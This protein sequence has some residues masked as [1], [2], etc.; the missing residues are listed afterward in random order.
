MSVKLDSLHITNMPLSTGEGWYCSGPQVNVPQWGRVA[1]LGAGNKMKSTAAAHTLQAVLWA[2][3]NLEVKTAEKTNTL[4]D[5][6]GW[7][8]YAGA[9]LVIRPWWQRVINVLRNG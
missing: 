8:T 7:V 2:W 3:G 4:V 1:C 5:N 6:Q 9:R